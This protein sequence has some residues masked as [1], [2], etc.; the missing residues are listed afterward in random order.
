MTATNGNVCVREREENTNKLSLYI[1]K[2]INDKLIRMNI[3]YEMKITYIYIFII[4]Y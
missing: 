4:K 1:K 3:D 2:W